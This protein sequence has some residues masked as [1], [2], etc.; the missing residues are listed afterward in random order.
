MQHF[1]LKV[2][3]AA[4]PL[5]ST[6]VVSL[7]AA[8][9]YVLHWARNPKPGSFFAKMTRILRVMPDQILLWGL[10]KRHYGGQILFCNG[11]PIGHIFHQ[12][13]GNEMHMFSVEVD[14][15]YRGR[16][17]ANQLMRAF[18]EEM[19]RR[20][21]IDYLRLSAGGDE[22][23][24]HMWEKA[25]HGEYALNYRVAECSKPGFGWLLISRH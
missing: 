22:T 17:Y 20:S 25:L 2:L 16:G 12:L 1:D 3:D 8:E 23:V 13:H 7:D 21:E 10:K 15:P 11:Q 4:T 24:K 18:L 6:A 9:R 19:G 14:E 5:S